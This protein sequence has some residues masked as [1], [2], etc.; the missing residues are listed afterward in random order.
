MGKALF[1]KGG[2]EQIAVSQFQMRIG[3][4]RSRVNAWSWAVTELLAR[5]PDARALEITLTYREKDDWQPDHI[6]RY[7]DKLRRRYKPRQLM[8]YA[9]VAELQERGAIHYHVLVVVSKEVFLATPD[10]S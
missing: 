4:I 3:R 8:A 6:S 5:Y 1:T 7:M 2:G 9:W 10:E